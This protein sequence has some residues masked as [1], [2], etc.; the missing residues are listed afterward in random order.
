MP[1]REDRCCKAL[2][3]K[4]ERCKNLAFTRGRCRVHAS[5]HSL[6]ARE[7]VPLVAAVI[8]SSS[9]VVTL[10]E[11]LV[12]HWPDILFIIER[13]IASVSFAGW[14]GV[15]TREANSARLEELKSA[16]VVSSFSTLLEVLEKRGQF[17]DT[18]HLPK[19]PRELK[20]QLMEAIARHQENLANLEGERKKLEELIREDCRSYLKRVEDKRWLYEQYRTYVFSLLVDDLNGHAQEGDKDPYWILQRRQWALSNFERDLP[21][22]FNDFIER[23]HTWNHWWWFVD[24][25]NY[26]QFLSL[27]APSDTLELRAVWHQ[28]GPHLPNHLRGEALA[29]LK[30][31]HTRLVEQL[32]RW[33]SLDSDLGRCSPH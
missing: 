22:N 26:L 30:V 3:R 4:G 5:E 20:N 14:N 29:E 32:E 16:T 11:K 25:I 9:A 28:T 1:Q 7:R 23:H 8:S 24:Y 12:Q 21:Q 6:S 31:V 19:L 10:V 17:P 15:N 2:T 13:I 18:A 27:P 33:W